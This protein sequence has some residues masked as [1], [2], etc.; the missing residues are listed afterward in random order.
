MKI[1]GIDPGTH[2]MGYATIEEIE[3]VQ[4]GE[5]YQQLQMCSVGTIQSHL[6]SHDDRLVELFDDV[7]TWLRSECPDV[8]AIEQ[9]R[10]AKHFNMIRIIETRGTVILAAKKLGIEVVHMNPSSVKLTVAGHGSAGKKDMQ[11]AVMHHLLLQGVIEPDDANDAMAMALA[12]YFKE[13]VLN[14]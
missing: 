6:E 3:M 14:R 10:S 4:Q 11:K 8:L 1:A 13:V 7:T 12:Y 9:L 2:L 5:T